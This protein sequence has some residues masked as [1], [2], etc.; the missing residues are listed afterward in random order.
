MSDK[1]YPIGKENSSKTFSTI[2]L[3]RHGQ[4]IGNASRVFLDPSKEVLSPTGRIQA[5]GAGEQLALVK[6]DRAYA[7]TLIRAQN[8]AKLI[9]QHSKYPLNDRINL[10]ERIKEVVS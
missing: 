10:D 6:F 5:N 4:T 7:S 8:T 9:L 2:Y 1:K 3:V